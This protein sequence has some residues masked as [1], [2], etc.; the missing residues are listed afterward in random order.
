MSILAKAV[1]DCAPAL[2]PPALLSILAGHA[3]LV[4]RQAS[5]AKI[6]PKNRSRTVSDARGPVSDACSLVS[7]ACGPAPGAFGHVPGACGP[8]LLPVLRPHVLPS[9]TISMGAGLRAQERE[10]LRSLSLPPGLPAKWVAALHAR[11]WT[12]VE[13]GGS[14][15]C[16]PLDTTRAAGC[17]DAAV[18]SPITLAPTHGPPTAPGSTLSSAFIRIA[19]V[20][21]MVLLPI[22]FLVLVIALFPWLTALV[23]RVAALAGHFIEGIG[24]VAFDCC[25]ALGPAISLDNNYLPTHRGIT[26]GI[27]NEIACSYARSVSSTQ[28]TDT[29]PASGS[30]LGPTTRS[31]ARAVQA[32]DNGNDG[33]DPLPSQNRNGDHARARC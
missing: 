28:G 1:P 23:S 14:L 31:R 32:R 4:D 8:S 22:V 3:A 30:T 9:S 2:E 6:S 10:C 20:T 29:G 17:A 33:D 13:K 5:Q 27:L 26:E 21:P 25:D 16:R 7:D 19:P 15:C 18:F 12:P 24:T 11:P